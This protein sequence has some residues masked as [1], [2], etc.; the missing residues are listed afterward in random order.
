MTFEE[1]LITQNT[2][3]WAITSR[4]IMRKAW[5]AATTAE[6][7]RCEKKCEELSRDEEPPYKD[8]ENTYLNGWL[9]ACNECKWVIHG[10]V[11]KSQYFKPQ[12][13]SEAAKIGMDFFSNN[14]RID[15]NS[16]TD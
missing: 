14:S 8:Y 12:E 16:P 4:E 15:N 6:Q 3:E 10:C 13:I 5:D 9:D 7:E 2:P 11:S 1:W